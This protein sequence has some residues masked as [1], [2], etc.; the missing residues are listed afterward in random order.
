MLVDSFE[1][2]DNRER[3]KIGRILLAF[4]F[5]KESLI[6]MI[7]FNKILRAMVTPPGVDSDFS[8]LTKNTATR[9]VMLRMF[10]FYV[11]FVLLSPIGL[12]KNPSTN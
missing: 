4:R 11:D 10:I 3:K 7:N 6:A 2:F 5:F 8:K 1:A 12:I 9:L